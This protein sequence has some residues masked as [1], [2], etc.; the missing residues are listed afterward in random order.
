MHNQFTNKTKVPTRTEVKSLIPEIT[1]GKHTIAKMDTAVGKQVIENVTVKNPLLRDTDGFAFNTH[2]YNFVDFN[3]AEDVDGYVATTFR[4][5]IE[6]C[7]KQGFSFTGSNPELVRRV[8][9][10]LHQ[11][12]RASR[13]TLHQIM[14]DLGSGL[15]KFCNGFLVMVREKPKKET[16]KF[17]SFKLHG[18]MAN[19]IVGLFYTEPQNMKPL[20]VDGRIDEWEYKNVSRPV[21]NQIFRKEDVFHV[22]WNKKGDDFFGTPW[23]L[24]AL[25]D[26]RMLRRLEEFVQM[27]ISKHLFP[28]YQ[29]KVG[30]KEQPAIEFEGGTS[31]V[32]KVEAMIGDLPTQ[33]VVFTSHRHEITAVSSDGALDIEK[34]IEHFDK[35][36]LSSCGLSGIDVG[37]GGTSNKASAGVMNQTRIDRCNRILR[38]LSEFFNTYIIED[39]LLSMGVDDVF[40]EENKVKLTFPDVDT[41]E[42]RSSE[43]HCIALFNAGAIT[44]NE[45]R[46]S[47]GRKPFESEDEWENVQQNTVGRIAAQLGQDTIMNQEKQKANIK[48]RTQPANKTDPEGKTKPKTPKND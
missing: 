22:F 19:P 1:K 16:S 38:T 26:I 13:T 33:G 31:E 45:L 14:E 37:R 41:A 46:K 18:K 43:D 11:I 29:Y 40:A 32:K 36:A 44:H 47:C 7:M 4:L 35:R 27:L 15:S 48:Q 23:I 42:R 3:Q 28:L 2:E 6:Q 5:T 10:R 34:Y 24:P 8:E 12:S 25:D 17:K 30:T 39:L 21:R 20:I 9:T